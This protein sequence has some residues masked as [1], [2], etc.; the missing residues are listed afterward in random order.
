MA[1]RL[2]DKAVLNR[3]WQNT[4]LRWDENE[5]TPA[6]LMDKEAADLRAEYT[7]L[8]RVAQKRLQKLADSEWADGEFYDE[9]AVGFK[10]LSRIGS[11]REL[12]A[13]LSDVAR[14]ISSPRSTLTGNE[15]IARKY[16]NTMHERGYDF[17]TR[18]NYH[19]VVEFFEDWRQGKLDVIYDSGSVAEVYELSKELKV[20]NAEDVRKN[21]EFWLE[22]REEIRQYEPPKGRRTTSSAAIRRSLKRKGV[23]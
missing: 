3:Q 14:F 5:Y 7:R 9:F 18:E 16:I 22:H 20:K 23:L 21:L 17:V 1:Q 13:A 10:R 15:Q 6:A 8:R 4:R 11:E 12:R 2:S 19:D